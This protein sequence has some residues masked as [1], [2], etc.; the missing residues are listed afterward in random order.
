ML[1]ERRYAPP[2]AVVHFNDRGRPSRKTRLGLTNREDFGEECKPWAAAGDGKISRT[3][4]ERR[5][6]P[7]IS[8]V[9]E[10]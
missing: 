3:V 10:V 5:F 4:K 9:E 7:I 1:V 2:F 8:T 6:E